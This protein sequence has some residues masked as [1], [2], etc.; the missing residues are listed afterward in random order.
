MHRVVWDLHY[1]GAEVIKKA[2]LDGG[3]PKVG[4]LVNPG[5]YTLKL[6]ADGKTETTKME[7]RLDPREAAEQAAG[8]KDG[9]PG[10]PVV[11][12]AGR[13]AETGPGDPRRHHQG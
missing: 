1:E 4:P 3:E 9:V 2:K 8:V 11:G 6:T 12:R 10:A 5:T 13:A 7:V